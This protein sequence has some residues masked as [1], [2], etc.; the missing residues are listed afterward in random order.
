[1]PKL[2]SDQPERQ[3]TSNPD[4]E[5]RPRRQFSQAYKRW[6]PV[7]G[8]MEWSAPPYSTRVRDPE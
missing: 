8:L 3:V 2:S 1:M 5:K 6:P 7:Y 4:W